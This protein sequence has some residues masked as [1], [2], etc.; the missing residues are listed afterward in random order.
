MPKTDEYKARIANGGYAMLRG[1][2]LSLSEES[3]GVVKTALD[4]CDVETMWPAWQEHID[5]ETA[6]KIRSEAASGKEH[7]AYN[8]RI[9][10]GWCPKC[11]SYCYGDCGL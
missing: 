5:V 11:E 2:R 6:K 10:N 8:A 9:A 1:T 4:L 7:T 3:Y